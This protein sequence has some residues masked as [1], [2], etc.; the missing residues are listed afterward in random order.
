M[1]L[2]QAELGKRLGKTQTY[3]ARVEGAKRD[4]RWA[5]VLEFARALELEPAFVPR[6]SIPAV[7][8]VLKL[9]A[10]DDVP[11]MAGETW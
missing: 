4:P 5:T 8:A 1:K 7:S 11:P 3:V 2:T 9:T 10:S 6:Q